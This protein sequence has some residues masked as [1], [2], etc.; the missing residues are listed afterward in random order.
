M[1]AQGKS[2]VKKTKL[3]RGAALFDIL[4]A[5]E[6][7]PPGSA[8][9]PF[10]ITRP[11]E[12]PRCTHEGESQEGRWHV[13]PIR[14]TDLTLWTQERVLGASGHTLRTAGLSWPGPEVIYSERVQ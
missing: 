11:L 3:A 12:I 6:R 4:A 13:P 14:N 8:V 9:S 1:L 5:L 10:H 7:L 2:S